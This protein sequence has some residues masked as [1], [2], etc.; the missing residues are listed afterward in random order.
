MNGLPPEVHYLSMS[1]QSMQTQLNTLAKLAEGMLRSSGN[2]HAG[3]AQSS[4][5]VLQDT[6][7]R[8][9]ARRTPQIAA[10]MTERLAA[11]APHN[12]ADLAAIQSY[13]QQLQGAIA[14]SMSPDRQRWLAD[15]MA[16]MPEFLADPAGKTAV[17][18]FVSY[19]QDFLAKGMPKE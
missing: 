12:G 18:A 4:E 10:P 16:R 14:S 19:Y 11:P 13:A 1:L 2:Q 5:A 15:N 17:N 6:V 8:E 9:V 7:N 3:A